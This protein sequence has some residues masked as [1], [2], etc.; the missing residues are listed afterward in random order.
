MRRP[1]NGSFEQARGCEIRRFPDTRIENWPDLVAQ[2]S[3]FTQR[4]A[5]L[6]PLVGQALVAVTGNARRGLIRGPAMFT[7]Q[8]RLDSDDLADRRNVRMVQGPTRGARRFPGYGLTSPLSAKRQPL[9]T[10]LVARFAAP[11]GWIKLRIKNNGW[12]AARPF[13]L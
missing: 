11:S 9:M 1:R 4:Q 12:A 7:V 5:R 8:I 3:L 6:L 2:A 13:L 10:T